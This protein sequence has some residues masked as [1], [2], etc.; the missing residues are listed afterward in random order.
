MSAQ[1]QRLYDNSAGGANHPDN[2]TGF[3]DLKRN[4]NDLYAALKAY[5]DNYMANTAKPD[6]HSRI[7]LTRWAS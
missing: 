7:R 2:Y 3:T 4:C 6:G 1:T 5:A